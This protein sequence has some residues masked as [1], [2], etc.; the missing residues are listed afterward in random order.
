METIHARS[1]SRRDF[2]VG[3]GRG[4][5]AAGVAAAWPSRRGFGG[6]ALPEL[7]V[8]EGVVDITPPVGIELAG[9]HRTAGNERRIA[10]IRQPTATRA[11]VLEHGS[12]RVCLVSLEI[13]G[14]GA[15]MATRIQRQ[16]EQQTGIPADCVRLCATH[17]HSAP[18]FFYLRQWGGTSPEYQQVVETKTVQAVKMAVEDLAPTALS[19]GK[20]RA[21]GGN[22]NRTTKNFQTDAQFG[23][24]STDA[25]RWLDTL[26][27]ALLF[28]RAGGRKSLLWYHFS[29]HPVCH[30]DEQA[31]PDWPGLVDRMTRDS[32]GLSP[33]YLQ[34][35]AGDV[36]PGDG[37]PW[38]GDAEQTSQAVHAALAAALSEAKRVPVDAIGTRSQEY[39]VPLDLDLFRSWLEAYRRDPAA[40]TKG[41]WVDAGFS[42]DWYRAN[43]QREWKAAGLPIPLSAIR[44][45]SLGLA[46]H[47]AE[48]YSYY[49]LVIRG[50][51]P[52]PDTLVV[53]Y[54]DG[55]I[56][57]LPD[58]AAFSTGEYAALVVPKILDYPPFTPTAAAEMSRAAVELLKQVAS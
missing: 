16:V 7:R 6:Q 25:E 18:A 43:A 21:V 42:E 5:L 45:G 12:T 27:Q 4:A 23:P 56:G 53:G 39:P 49:G 32:H 1:L 31:G 48:L 34:G 2:L 20:S 54:T 17:T 30:A 40:C 51:S 3:A 44:L 11:L 14:L 57:Y 9:F 58:P 36:N 13:A 55:L 46:F 37:D 41:P 8:G 35:H 24:E 47:P 15:E 19:V 29:A 38:R 33:A 26:L 52:L 22:F 28:E 10:G 50:Q